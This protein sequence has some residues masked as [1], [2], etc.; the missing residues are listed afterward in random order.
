MSHNEEE[1]RV[2]DIEG[3]E[4]VTEEEPEVAELSEKDLKKVAGAGGRRW[5]IPGTPLFD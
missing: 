5:E 4:E 1:Q 2:E 3:A